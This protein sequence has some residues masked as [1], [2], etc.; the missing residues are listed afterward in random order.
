[1]FLICDGVSLVL[2]LELTSSGFR[3]EIIIIIYNAHDFTLHTIGFILAISVLF[4]T[5][6]LDYL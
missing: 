5:M 2:Q 6:Y 1:M 3:Q 4:N